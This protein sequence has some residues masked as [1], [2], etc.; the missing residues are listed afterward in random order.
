MDGFDL[1]PD[2]RMLARVRRLSPLLRRAHGVALLGARHALRGTDARRQVDRYGQD[3]A[4]RARG[5]AA[6]DA[7]PSRVRQFNERPFSRECVGGRHPRGF[8]RDAPG[9]Q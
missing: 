9:T 4:G 1:E 2:A 6:L 8:R 5:P 7:P 3:R